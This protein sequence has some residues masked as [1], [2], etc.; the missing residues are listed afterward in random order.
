VWYL[1]VIWAAKLGGDVYCRC[2]FVVSCYSGGGDP[3]FLGP[4]DVTSFFKLLYYLCSAGGYLSPCACV[5]V[6]RSG[7]HTA[8]GTETVRDYC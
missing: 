7:T 5:C 4:A 2:S 3:L 1:V 6:C 8:V